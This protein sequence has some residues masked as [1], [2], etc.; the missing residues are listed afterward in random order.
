MN[1]INKKIGWLNGLRGLACLSVYLVH[2]DAI[3][4]YCDMGNKQLSS[5]YRLLHSCANSILN[6]YFWLVVF[7]LISGVLA[8]NKK[9]NSITQLLCNIFFRYIRFVIPLF[10]A[11]IFSF[12]ISRTIG[13]HNTEL[14]PLL[15][16]DTLVSF[17]NDRIQIV[18]ILKSAFLFDSKINPPLWTI[19]GIFWGSC[20]VY[21]INYI[22]RNMKAKCQLSVSVVATIF[23]FIIGKGN[24]TF[25]YIIA[26]TISGSVL[27][28]VWRIPNETQINN[29]VSTFLVL[30]AG[31]VLNS[32]FGIISR[33]LER[34]IPLDSFFIT[35]NV[36]Y[37]LAIF[38]FGFIHYSRTIKNILEF[39]IVEKLG[40]YAFSVYVIHEP[41][42]CS[43]SLILIKMLLTL[44]DNYTL[45]VITSFFVTSATLAFI[46]FIYENT[47]ARMENRLIQLTKKL[48]LNAIYY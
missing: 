10:F 44:T 17:Y 18:D 30:L 5:I 16:S 25:F 27:S 20:T 1:S 31:I 34:Y 23:F 43:V 37:I 6:V 33:W 42:I 45:S 41:I 8:E 13:F 47:I 21:V 28:K 22:T 29:T 46:V 19:R 26:S 3:F 12:A 2:F 4:I 7:Y 35:L 15:G 48:L 39:S 36:D 9:S 24:N 11:G 32:M 14:A 40:K 38:F